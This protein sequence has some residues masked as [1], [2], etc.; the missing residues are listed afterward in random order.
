MRIMCPVCKGYKAGER[1]HQWAVI[2]SIGP[3]GRRALSCIAY[4]DYLETMSYYNQ[5]SNSASTYLHLGISSNSD[6]ISITK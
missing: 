5:Y 4:L 3:Q 1:G 2:W 6:F